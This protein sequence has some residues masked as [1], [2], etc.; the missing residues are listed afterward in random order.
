M[1]LGTK[2]LAAAMALVIPVPFLAIAQLPGVAVRVPTVRAHE[3]GGEVVNYWSRSLPVRGLADWSVRAGH[4]VEERVNPKVKGLNYLILKG[5]NRA[6]GWRL[7]S[8]LHR[9]IF[10]AG[11]NGTTSARQSG[12][13]QKLRPYQRLRDFVSAIGGSMTNAPLPPG[14]IWTISLWG[15]TRTFRCRNDQVNPLDGLYKSDPADPPHTWADFPEGERTPL[16][17][18]V[19]YRLADL[20]RQGAPPRVI[21]GGAVVLRRPTAAAPPEATTGDRSGESAEPTCTNCFFPYSR[22]C[23]RENGWR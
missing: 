17:D 18:D 23:C 1:T 21:D 4:R 8:S 19:F 11:K 15:E 14:R 9:E 10:T 3:L 5:P 12:M 16:V 6:T 20:M 7:I 2:R 13:T 22:C